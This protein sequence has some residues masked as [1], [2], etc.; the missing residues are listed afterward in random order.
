MYFS[1]RALLPIWNA[2]FSLL[3]HVTI[4]KELTSTAACQGWWQVTWAKHNA[5]ICC[6]LRYLASTRHMLFPVVKTRFP[7]L[8]NLYIWEPPL[9]RC[10]LSWRFHPWFTQAAGLVHPFM[11][12][13]HTL[14]C[15]AMPQHMYATLHDLCPCAVAVAW[16][17]RMR[18]LLLRGALPAMPSLLPWLFTGPLPN[19]PN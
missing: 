1:S 8:W 10:I 9:K 6:C 2:F 4:C 17:P 18:M 19:H 13:F 11:R 5:A 14:R 15:L 12:L 7:L 3:A 16:Q